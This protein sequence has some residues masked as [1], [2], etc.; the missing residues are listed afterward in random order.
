LWDYVPPPPPFE[1]WLKPEFDL[2]VD[3]WSFP[4]SPRVRRLAS[5][6]LGDEQDIVRAV[7]IDAADNSVATAGGD[8]TVKVWIVRVLR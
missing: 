1:V 3:V 7:A 4:P 8:G 2:G 6:S 5:L